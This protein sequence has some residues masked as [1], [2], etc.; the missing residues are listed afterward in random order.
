MVKLL[1]NIKTNKLVILKIPSSQLQFAPNENM[2]TG[3]LRLTF[4]LKI[5]SEP[6][7]VC[8]YESSEGGI[9]AGITSS[10]PFK[11]HWPEILATEESVMKM[12][13]SRHFSYPHK[14]FGNDA[15]RDKLNV[16]QFHLG[17]FFFLLKNRLFWRCISHSLTFIKH[18]FF[19]RPFL[20]K[21][22]GQTTIV[23]AENSCSSHSL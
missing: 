23:T 20:K 4:Q 11:T 21:L 2:S 5:Q 10:W 12:G 14:I 16:L 8:R 1:W 22:L 3:P 18:P 19:A 7:I 13:W 15:V 6:Q 9:W 17:F